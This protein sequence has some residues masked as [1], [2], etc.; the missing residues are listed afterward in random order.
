MRALCFECK[1]TRFFTEVGWT[2][3]KMDIYKCPKSIS[4]QQTQIFNFFRFSVD[5]QIT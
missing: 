5:S 4:E 2:F 1:K 3:M